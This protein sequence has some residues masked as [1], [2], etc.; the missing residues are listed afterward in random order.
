MKPKTQP[1]IRLHPL[2][3]SNRSLLDAICHLPVHQHG[4]VGSASIPGAPVAPGFLLLTAPTLP[5]RNHAKGPSQLLI[6]KGPP[7]TPTK[8]PNAPHMTQQ[9]W[10]CC[11]CCW[12]GT[13]AAAATPISQGFTP[14]CCGAGSTWCRRC[15]C[16]PLARRWRRCPSSQRARSRRYEPDFTLACRLA[17]LLKDLVYHLVRAFG[18]A[19]TEV[20][21]AVAGGLHSQ[22]L[23]GIVLENCP[24]CSRRCAAFAS[25]RM[26]HLFA[27][28]PFLGDIIHVLPFQRLCEAPAGV[29]GALQG[30]GSR[31]AYV[32]TSEPTLQGMAAGP[33][34]CE[35]AAG[36]HGAGAVSSQCHPDNIHEVLFKH[37]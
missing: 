32:F 4:H 3:T 5:T 2:W 10:T 29:R 22:C 26:Q 37:I 21:Y 25:R 19:L 12:R 18:L 20:P 30:H 1:S 23:G 6:M 15:C 24:S 13:A 33:G 8:S 14:R 34:L 17:G 28:V 35:A 16:A 31:C 11:R 36:V 27:A 7:T 9:A